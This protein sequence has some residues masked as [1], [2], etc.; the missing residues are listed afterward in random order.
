MKNANTVKAPTRL[1]S[2]KK[3]KEAG[4]VAKVWMICNALH[5]KA[6]KEVIAACVAAKINAGTA[7]TQYQAWFA[8][9]HAA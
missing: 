6:R 8:E 2:S 1:V 3:F 9:A 4:T 5:T 7:R